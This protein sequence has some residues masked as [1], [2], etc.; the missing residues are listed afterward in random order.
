MSS[1]MNLGIPFPFV[2][3][4]RGFLTNRQ[5]R[6]RLNSA[7]SGARLFREG[8]PQGSVLSPL[9]FLFVIN[10]LRPRLQSDVTSMFADDVGLIAQSNSLDRAAAVIEED[11]NEVH[12][13]S[14]EKKL[15][16]NIAK[17]EVSFFSPD[18]HEAKPERLPAI[19][20]GPTPLK[21][22]PTPVFLDVTYDRVLSVIAR[23][24]LWGAHSRA[25]I[26][27]SASHGCLPEAEYLSAP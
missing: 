12:R 6:V 27:Q 21:F 26:L 17:C 16:L 7:T 24:H 25:L 13:W 22:I 15:H 23:R 19:H 4:I 18:P 2:R 11:V 3:W 20:V 1:L 8:L 9:L 5:A 10:D 14:K